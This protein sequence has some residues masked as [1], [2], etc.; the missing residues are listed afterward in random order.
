M[1]GNIDRYGRARTPQNVLPRIPTYHSPSYNTRTT[2][3]YNPGFWDRIN[4][5]FAG[6]GDWFEDNYDTIEDFFLEKIVLPLVYIAIIGVGIGVIVIWITEGFLSFVLYTFIAIFIGGI[7]VGLS[8]Y[9]LAICLFILRLILWLLRYV[10]TNAISFFITILVVT[11]IVIGTSYYSPS[12][13][14][15]SD[16]ETTASSYSTYYCTANSLNIRSYASTNAPIIG[17]L[18]KGDRVQVYEIKN[19][20]AKIKYNGRTGYVSKK[21]ITLY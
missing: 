4:D 17:K 19:G 8:Y 13:I 11:G 7:I 6:I 2:Y 12:N 1:S 14:S 21:Y 5:F 10:F 15:K 18:K 16:T 20:F 9:A 3:S